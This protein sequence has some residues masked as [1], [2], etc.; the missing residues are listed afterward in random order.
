[1]GSSW[2]NRAYLTCALL[3]SASQVQAARYQLVGLLASTIST[4]SLAV[5]RGED[6]VANVLHVGG[7]LAPIRLVA[8]TDRAILVATG[9]KQFVL[10]PGDWT[11]QG[12]EPPT[13]HG[14]VEVRGDEVLLTE[15]MRTYISGPYLAKTMMAASAY[16][17]EEGGQCI[18]F[19]V[20]QIDRGSIYEMAGLHNGDII[21]E[22]AGMRLRDP[23]GAIRALMSV[24][25]AEEFTVGYRRAGV[26]RQL[27]VRIQ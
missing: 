15:A 10:R 2:I 3:A 18:G 27:K 5:F 13:L 7:W 6:E 21:T 22:I 19:G 14:G 24:A 1:M 20:D 17:V 26:D 16:P 11:D 25:K 12:E 8:V 4:N 9:G 23:M